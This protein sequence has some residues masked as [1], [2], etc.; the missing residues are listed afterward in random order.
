[1]GRVKGGSQPRAPDPIDTARAQTG[2]NVSTTVANSILGNVNQVTPYGTLTYEQTGTYD[3]TDPTTGETYN[4]PTMTATQTL[5]DDQQQMLDNTNAAGISATEAAANMS[6]RLRDSSGQPLTLDGL[7]AGGSA[8]NIGNA[9]RFFLHDSGSTTGNPANRFQDASGNVAGAGQITRSY[10][11]DFS[12]DRQRVEDALMSRLNPSLDR[13]KESLRT[14]LINQGINEG[15]EAFDRAM[16]RFGE[17]SNDARMQAILAGGQEQS[18]L[19]GLEAQRAG[20]EN[21]AQQQ[22]FGQNVMRTQMQNDAASQNNANMMARVGFNNSVRDQN[23]ADQYQRQSRMD[24]DRAIERD[25]L[26]ALR[27]QPINEISALLGSGQVTQPNFVQTSQPRMPTTDVAGLIQSDYNNQLNA[28]N[29]RQANT[30]SLLGG[31]F[32][33]GGT[34]GAAALMS[35]R[36]LKADIRRIGQHKRLPLYEW[37]YL[38]S[39][40]K[41]V[42]FM[43]D[44]VVK[45]APQAVTT[46]HGGYQAV[47]YAAAM[48]AA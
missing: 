44:E 33:V 32:G 41:Q 1:M 7:S 36:R 20:F 22:Q 31:L 5:S 26:F 9:G 38:G 11:T 23:L 34:L 24:Q 3:W 45:I 18:R 6:D 39:G 12:Q 21:S 27:N 4:L 15:S 17:Q 42:G 35:D 28:F 8:S 25:E 40:A 37:R 19:A 29:Q 46:L 13:D 16:N 10:G 2:T 47:D 14:S 30:N 48:E 43:A